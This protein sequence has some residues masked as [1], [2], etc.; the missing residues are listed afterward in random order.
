[1]AKEKIRRFQMDTATFLSIWNNHMPSVMDT[2]DAWRRFVLNLF[3]RYTEGTEY[4]NME[5]LKEEDPDW[6]KW[7]ESKKYAYLSDKAYSK[8][9]GIK[10]RVKDDK[11]IIIPLPKGY[12]TRNG[13]RTSKRLTT[14]DIA[15]FFTNLG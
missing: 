7:D 4:R 15:G 10:R 6:K 11:N 13:T 2:D 12:L 5:T 3:E 14:D 9:I 1:M 8:C